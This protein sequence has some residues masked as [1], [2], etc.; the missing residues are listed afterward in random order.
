M[1]FSYEGA[2]L[3]RIIKSYTKDG[4][5]YIIE[6]LDGSDATY[7]SSN[8]KEVEKLKSVMIEQAK[9]RDKVFSEKCLDKIPSIN[10][11]G[12]LVACLGINIAEISES[13]LLELVCIFVLGVNVG[14]IRANKRKRIELKKYKLFL[15][16]LDVL[17]EKE[18]NSPKYTKQYEFDNIY[19]QPLM[20]ETIDNFSL[21]DIKRVYKTYKL[22]KNSKQ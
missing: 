3:S 21:N 6:Y 17:G 8:D 13:M 15:E 18:L 4:Y 10:I 22:E 7:F 11:F 19:A 16:L 2:D 20:I 14:Q 12:T 1:N 9:Q 5:K